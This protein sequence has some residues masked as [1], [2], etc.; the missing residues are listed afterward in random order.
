MG[1][2]EVFRRARESY[3][4][5]DVAT[6]YRTLRLFRELGVVTEVGIA[7]RLHF[8]LTDPAARHHHMVC[9]V[10]GSAFDL[11]PYYL[12]QFRET[13][14]REFGF[15]P[16]LGNFTVTG[17]CVRCGSRKELRGPIGN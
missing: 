4:Y 15:E 17:T 1:V 14:S 9:K 3:P 10:C 8:E 12:E 16:D 5:L 6:V 2:D 13:L 7:D 11:S